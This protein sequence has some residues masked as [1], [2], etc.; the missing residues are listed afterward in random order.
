MIDNQ[1]SLSRLS[2][3]KGTIQK[4]VEIKLRLTIYVV[5]SIQNCIVLG[6]H[7]TF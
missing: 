6:I 5:D 3:N 4:L 1:Q 2:R 7:Y